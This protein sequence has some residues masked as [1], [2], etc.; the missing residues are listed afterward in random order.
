ML[1]G[2]KNNLFKHLLLLQDLFFSPRLL[3]L[4]IGHYQSLFLFIFVFSLHTAEYH[5][6]WLDLKPGL[7]VSDTTIFLS[8]HSN[9]ALVIPEWVM[10]GLFYIYFLIFSNNNTIITEINV[11]KLSI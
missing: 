8:V 6:P 7:L 4:L 3:L 11:K 5:C 2:W 10:I 9:F 1:A